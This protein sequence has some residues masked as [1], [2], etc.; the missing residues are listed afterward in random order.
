[1]KKVLRDDERIWNRCKIVSS[2]G[3]GYGFFD[4]GRTADV[5]LTS[6]EYL[7]GEPTLK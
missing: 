2:E 4:F 5:F 1:M 6:L 3:R 7:C